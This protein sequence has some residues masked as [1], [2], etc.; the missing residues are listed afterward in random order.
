[1]TVENNRITWGAGR[2]TRFAMLVG[3]RGSA[4]QST[5]SPVPG[6]RFENDLCV[7]DRQDVI[8]FPRYL[9][10]RLAVRLYGKIV[11]LAC[12]DDD[13]GWCQLIVAA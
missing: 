1:M 9:T 10:L 2:L 8:A 7:D 11:T 13:E 5:E 12:D 6:W 4:A 3:H